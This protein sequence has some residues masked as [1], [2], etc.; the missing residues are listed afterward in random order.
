MACSQVINKPNHFINEGSSS[1]DVT[2]SSNMSF[3]RYYGI[4]LS[5]FEEHHHNITY[6]IPD[7][8][9]LLLLLYYREI[10]DYKNGDNGNR[11]TEKIDHKTQQWMSTLIISTL[12][13]RSIFSKCYYRNHFEY[14]K[15]TLLNQENLQ[16]NYH[17]SKKKKKHYIATMSS[18]LD[19]PDT[20]RI[21]NRQK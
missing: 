8:L 20:G 13:E 14:N 10:W 4:E 5:I 19:C 18:K 16:K 1:I 6:G 12:K 21:F 9:V 15:E 17:R 3:A 7:F 2:F 11:K